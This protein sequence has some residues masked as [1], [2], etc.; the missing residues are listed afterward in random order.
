MSPRHGRAA[1]TRGARRVVRGASAGIAAALLAAAFVGGC[2]RPAS[3]G[4]RSVFVYF[5]REGECDVHPFPRQVPDGDPLAVTRA[6]LLAL[7]AGPTPEEATQGY[8][9]AIPDTLDVLRHRM[10]YLAFDYDAPHHG[11]RVEIRSLAPGEDG[12]LTVDF[13]R[14]INAYDRGATRVC[15]IFREVQ[16]TVMQFPQWKGVR[17]AVEGKTEGILQP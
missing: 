8:A 16:A 7:L 14:E 11:K 17:L 12:V 10:R 1:S 6:A 13:S 2:A 4:T 9:S 15:A 3:D 5:P